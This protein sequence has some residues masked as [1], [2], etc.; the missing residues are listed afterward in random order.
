[1]LTQQALLDGGGITFELCEE[2][3]P[4][5]ATSGE[6]KT[7]NDPPNQPQRPTT[8]YRGVKSNLK[9]SV[10]MV[11]C[12]HGRD[13]PNSDQAM[14]LMVF[15]YRLNYAVRDNYIASVMTKFIFKDS[16]IGEGGANPQVVAYAPF[17]REMRW[18]KTEAD[19]KV[20]SHWDAKIG[21]S[22]IAS[23]DAGGGVKREVLHQQRYFDRG[24]AGREF[25]KGKWDRVWWFLQQNDS[26][27]HGLASTF[28]VAILLKRSSNSAFQGSFQLR[29]EAGLWQ[30]FKS[31]VRRFFRI[32]ED[33]PIN[34]D[35][36]RGPEG[37]KWEKFRKNIDPG[38]L[39]TLA[40]DDEL[41]KL[42]EVWDPDL[43]T[44]AAPGPLV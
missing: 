24:Q 32:K 9:A 13:N 41:V 44:F 25:E 39:G 43:G 20:E 33:D 38:N 19:V 1:M 22:Y 14:S 37:R 34:F 27:N 12:V 10:E 29:L 21:V 8:T 5:E 40:E 4:P 18:N 31:G 23:A 17:E 15:D 36:Q 7:N 30:G 3:N 2:E 6:T 16:E 35:P 11:A 28:S 42:A 26:Q